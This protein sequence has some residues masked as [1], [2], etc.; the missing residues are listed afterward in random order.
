MNVNVVIDTPAGVRQK[1]KYAF[2]LLFR[3][4]RI[5]VEYGNSFKDGEPNIY[6]GTRKPDSSQKLI[7]VL[8]APEFEKCLSESTLPDTENISWIPYAEKKLPGLFPVDGGS[9]TFDVAAATFVLGSNYQDLISTDRDEFD[10]LR[11]MDSL[12]DR[13]GVLELPVVNYYSLILKETIEK[14]YGLRIDPK[15]YS[16]SDSAIALTHDV[17]YTSSLNFK[18]IKRD[19]LGHS[20][21]NHAGLNQSE[22]VMKLTNWIAAFIGRNPA[23]AGLSFLKDVESAR[24]IRSTFFI[25]SGATAKE[26]VRY[27]LKTPHMR[28][29]IGS[30]VENGFEIGIHPSMKTY[31]DSDRFVKEMNLLADAA[32]K[33]IRSVRQ[34]YLKFTAGT[35]PGIWEDA[36]LKYDSTLGFS[37]KVGFRNS[38]AFP[39]PLFNF[40]KDEISPVTELPLVLMDGTLADNRMLTA[41]ETFDRMVSLVQATK[42][43]HGAASILFHNS[44]LDPIDF[45]DYG[46][47]YKRLVD[48]ISENGIK[49]GPVEDIVEHFN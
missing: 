38:I 41:E 3:P 1:I 32:G 44:L 20:L 13:L 22:R 16:E 43:A 39:F 10:R 29:F 2:A 25:K 49:M 46:T 26:D 11:A 18:I 4:M 24:N 35:T 12:Q 9:L 17:D 27:S 42:D 45:P 34:H 14:G 7:H 6:Y 5:G 23:R 28:K 31:I 37:R 19:I 36:G 33:P 21:L 8:S 15:K 40:K 47:I 48:R 30:L